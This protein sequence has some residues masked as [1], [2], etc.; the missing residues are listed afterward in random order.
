MTTLGKNE[1]NRTVN[2]PNT[3]SGAMPEK[4]ELMVE[5]AAPAIAPRRMPLT[6][7]SGQAVSRPDKPPPR[8]IKAVNIGRPRDGSAKGIPGKAR[9][10][11]FT[12]IR[13]YTRP[14]PAPRMKPIKRRD[15]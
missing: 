14:M 2:E 11:M 10:L 8:A 7:S 5:P 1:K 6:D 15:L 12:E 4:A 3:L 13:P 9:K